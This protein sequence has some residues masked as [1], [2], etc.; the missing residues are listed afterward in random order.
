MVN[1]SSG[2]RPSIGSV[3]RICRR[4][5]VTGSATPA[6]SP[7]ARDQAPAAQMTTLVATGPWL[8]CT[9]V[10]SS[11]WVAML[12]TSHPTRRCA[13]SARAATA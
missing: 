13:P 6:I 7:Q 8:V 2:G 12:V 4:T 10:I 3:K 11:S 5:G 1:G 9:P